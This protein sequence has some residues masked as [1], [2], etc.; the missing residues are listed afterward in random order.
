MISSLSRL[1]KLICL[2][3]RSPATR[4]ACEG[5][6]IELQKMDRQPEVSRQET[7]DKEFN[8]GM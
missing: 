5:S 1:I 3:E 6:G 2:M 4:V 7:T 8:G